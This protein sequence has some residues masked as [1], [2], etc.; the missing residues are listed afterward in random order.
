MKSIA[1]LTMVFLP[2][3]FFATLFS[4]PSLGWDQPK[5]FP[6]YWTYTIPFTLAPF[7]IWAIFSQRHELRRWARRS[8]ILLPLLP[9]WYLS[10]EPKMPDYD[11][12]DKDLY[13]I[14]DNSH[15]EYLKYDKFLRERG[16]AKRK[17]RIRID[18]W[19][20]WKRNEGKKADV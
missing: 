2:G 14:V 16:E 12:V 6:L 9:I 1:V 10:P 5:D 20:P 15:E 4:M 7:I 13:E 3:T 8:P 18:K 17:L 19:K 11:A